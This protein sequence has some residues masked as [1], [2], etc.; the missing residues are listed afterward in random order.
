MTLNVS[1]QRFEF[2]YNKT[3]DVVSGGLVSQALFYQPAPTNLSLTPG[4]PLPPLKMSLLDQGGK[5]FNSSDGFRV[6]Y[7]RVRVLKRIL[8]SRRLLE[9]KFPGYVDE[10]GDT[11]PGGGQQLVPIAS[12]SN[13]IVNASSTLCSAGS[14]MIVYEIVEVVNGTVVVIS[15]NVPVVAYEVLV[16]VGPAAVFSVECVNCTQ[17]SFTKL[18]NVVAVVFRDVGRNVLPPSPLLAQC[19]PHSHFLPKS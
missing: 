6:F 1:V 7:T 16:L 13:F 12:S 14:S 4:A 5:P 11:C 8:A 3:L 15:G 9:S 2:E 19:Q 17:T 18:V 10:T